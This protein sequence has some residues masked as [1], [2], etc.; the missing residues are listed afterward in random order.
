MKQQ[1][2][3]QELVE[4]TSNPHVKTDRPHRTTRRPDR[5]GHNIC[6]KTRDKAGL[7]QSGIY[8]NSHTNN[9]ANINAMEKT[10]NSVAAMLSPRERTGNNYR[11]QVREGAEPTCQGRISFPA[12]NSTCE[13]LLSLLH[14]SYINNYYHSQPVVA[15]MVGKSNS[16]SIRNSLAN[17]NYHTDASAN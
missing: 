8:K 5:Y 17:Q 16:T 1:T 12:E 11:P 7:I 10:L 3:S 15:K 4:V 9:L 6:E 13:D 2:P 14:Q